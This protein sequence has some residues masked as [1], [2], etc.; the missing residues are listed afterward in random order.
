MLKIGTA[1]EGEAKVLELIGSLDSFTAPQLEAEGINLVSKGCKSMIMDLTRLEY[2]S[3][4]GLRAVLTIAKK[5]MPSGG[6]MAMF[7]ASGLVEN[8]FTMS[9]FDMFIPIRKTKAEALA[10]TQANDGK[11]GKC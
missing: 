4:S 1:S 6:K 9:G 2:I 10:A 11:A 7:G 5:L 8:V 3:S